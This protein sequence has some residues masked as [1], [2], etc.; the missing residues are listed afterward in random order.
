MIDVERQAGENADDLV[1]RYD[2][3]ITGLLPWSDWDLIG[4]EVRE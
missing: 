3:D 1:A 2:D 4:A